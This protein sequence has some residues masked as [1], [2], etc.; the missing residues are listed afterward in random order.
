MKFFGAET[1]PLQLILDTFPETT[2]EYLE[3]YQ[4][5]QVKDLLLGGGIHCDDYEE[6]VM[7]LQLLDHMGLLKCVQTVIDNNIQYKV[8]KKKYV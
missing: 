8:T 2:E 1:N 5:Q 7:C 3:Y 6:V 4:L